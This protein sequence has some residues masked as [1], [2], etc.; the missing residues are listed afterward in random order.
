MKNSESSCLKF[1]IQNHFKIGSIHTKAFI[2]NYLVKVGLE[3]AKAT[4]IQEYFEVKDTKNSNG[5]NC[6]KIIRKL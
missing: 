1:R 5:E 6:F 2:K 3:K 4:T